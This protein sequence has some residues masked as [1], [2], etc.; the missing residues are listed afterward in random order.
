MVFLCVAVMGT[1]PNLGTAI[2]M[3][4]SIEEDANLEEDGKVKVL[5]IVIAVHRLTPSP[6]GQCNIGRCKR[7][8]WLGSDDMLDECNSDTVRPY[9]FMKILNKQRR[10]LRD[11]AM[12]LPMVVVYLGRS[13]ISRQILQH[14]FTNVV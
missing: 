2:T 9:I 5:A 14:A 4:Y 13:E 8:L 7:E 11:I 10:R 12:Y 6:T 1:G 3:I